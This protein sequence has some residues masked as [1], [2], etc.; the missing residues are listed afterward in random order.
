MRQW[1]I[2]GVSSG[3]GR[4]LA[5]AVAAQGDKV[6]GT[7]RTRQGQQGFD[8]LHPG[9]TQGFLLD[10]TDHHAVETAIRA[11]DEAL[12]GIDVL[13]NNAGYSFE[14]TLEE[15][16]WEDIYGQFA[17]NFF[18]PIAVMKAVLPMMR[19]RRRGL[20]MNVTSMAG[21]VAGAGIGAYGSAKLA[22]EGMS[23]AVA[24]EVAPFGI[25]VMTVVPGAF[26]TDLGRNRRSAADGIADYLPQNLAR[27]Q[28][29]AALSGRQRG[30]PRKAATAIIAAAQAQNPPR[31]LILGMDAVAAVA[32]DLQQFEA[33]I[34]TWESL[35]YGLDLG[36]ED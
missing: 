33:E 9:L 13:V 30:D 31:R 2:T 24:Q 6:A 7:L 8:E 4:E 35:S 12:G 34:R 1:L 3:L 22:L 21:Y 29:L 14:G 19:A 26:R 10:V 23:R 18:G 27:R 11:A 28:R 17:A 36:G 20:I 16:A 15:S 5:R 25:H 32:D